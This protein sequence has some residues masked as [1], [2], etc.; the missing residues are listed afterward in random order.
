MQADHALDI[1]YREHHDGHVWMRSV[2]F[3]VSGVEPLSG[4][5]AGGYVGLDPAELVA[6]EA[7]V[8]P[9]ASPREVTLYRCECGEL[10]CGAV[11]AR[12]YRLD[13]HVVWDQ[14]GAGNPPPRDVNAPQPLSDALSFDAEHYRAAMSRLNELAARHP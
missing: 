3:L 2:A 7:L 1:E 13:D 5:G 8:E 11:V 6:Q 14:F 10:G 12:C 9:A 4:L